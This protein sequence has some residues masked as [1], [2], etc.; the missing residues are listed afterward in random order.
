MP[1]NVLRSSMSP[2]KIYLPHDPGALPAFILFTA[3]CV[4]VCGWECVNES[5][6]CR[7]SSFWKWSRGRRMQRSV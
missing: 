5:I 2:C 6:R 7:H 3:L 4:S 1:R